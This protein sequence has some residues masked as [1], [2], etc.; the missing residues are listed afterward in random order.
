MDQKKKFKEWWTRNG[1][2]ARDPAWYKF[3]Q[4]GKPVKNIGAIEL[5]TYIKEFKTEFRTDLLK[6]VFA[7]SEQ[8]KEEI[9]PEIENKPLKDFEVLIQKQKDLDNEFKKFAYPS[10]SNLTLNMTRQLPIAITGLGD[11]HLGSSCLDSDKL[12]ADIKIIN[13]TDGMYAVGLG[14]WLQNFIHAKLINAA[15][16][17]SRPAY[18]WLLVELIVKSLADSLLV[19][20]PGNHDLWTQELT[21]V[22]KMASIAREAQALYHNDES[23]T[24]IQIKFDN[25][26]YLGAFRHKP[27]GNSRINPMLGCKNI[28]RD[29]VPYDFCF[30]GHQHEF[31]MEYFTKHNQ[32][33]IALA[34]G[35]YKIDDRFGKKLGYPNA[36]PIMPTVVLMPDRREMVAFEDIKTAAKFLKDMRK[37]Y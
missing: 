18:Q 20:N 28:Y 3:K 29:L 1:M 25:V 23:P 32:T 5:R 10:V 26:E 22:D 37:L 16:G 35:S 6:D 19:L 17:D 8:A 30:V 15:R 4:Q 34:C 9:T 2:P 21:D 31:G 24:T 33:R 13:K 27:I 12:I 14:D 7:S 11:L 36:R